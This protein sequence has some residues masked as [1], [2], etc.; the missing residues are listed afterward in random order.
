MLTITC[1]AFCANHFSIAYSH[2]PKMSTNNS[3]KNPK[4]A[5]TPKTIETIPNRTCQLLFV[6]VKPTLY[7]RNRIKV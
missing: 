1:V 5:K 3:I 6:S 2:A 7:I 4:N